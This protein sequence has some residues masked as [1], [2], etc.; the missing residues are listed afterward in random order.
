MLNDLY[1]FKNLH[2]ISVFRIYSR[3]HM[4]NFYSNISRI[5]TIYLGIVLTS[6]NKIINI[7]C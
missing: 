2:I 7:Y 4:F 3:K 6:I 1:Y 5:C